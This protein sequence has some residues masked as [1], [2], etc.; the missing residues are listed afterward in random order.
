MCPVQ[1]PTAER[2]RAATCPVLAGELGLGGAV[3]GE[4]VVEQGEAV[5]VDQAAAPAQA[6][7]AVDDQGALV[8][9][10]EALG[11]RADPVE[12][13]GVG[14]AGGQDAE[15]FGAGGVAVA[16]GVRAEPDGERLAGAVELVAD[17]EVVLAAG[18][19]GAFHGPAGQG[20]DDDRVAVLVE[21]DLDDL[22][23]GGGDLVRAGPAGGQLVGDRCRAGS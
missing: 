17:V 3:L 5:Q 15:L 13:L 4:R 14:V 10:V 1:R 8:V 18:A 11:V 22:A 6:H 9:G 7:G 12:A 23:A 16:A 19:A 20:A 21:V 2:R